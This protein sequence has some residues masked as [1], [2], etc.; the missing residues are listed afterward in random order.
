MFVVA[1]YFLELRRKHQPKILLGIAPA[2]MAA[3]DHTDMLSVPKRDTQ[4]QRVARRTLATRSQAT[5]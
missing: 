4:T 5:R 3:G 1:R 2:L